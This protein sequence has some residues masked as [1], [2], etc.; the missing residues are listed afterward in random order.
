MLFSFTSSGEA[1][2]LLGVVVGSEG[3]FD[4]SEQVGTAKNPI[5]KPE[6]KQK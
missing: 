5:N 6:N 2:V 3:E 1:V 4:E